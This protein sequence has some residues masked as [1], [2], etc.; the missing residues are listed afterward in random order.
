MVD[1]TLHREIHELANSVRRL[2]SR[3]RA[4]TDRLH[5]EDG[6]SA[7]RR[8]VLI[9][10]Y[11][12]GELTVPALAAVRSISR[13]II[14]TQV[15]DLRGLGYVVMKP[16]PEHKRSFLIVLTDS[17]RAFVET[18]IRREEAYMDQLGWQPEPHDLATCI[19]VLNEID[20]RLDD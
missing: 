6:L 14:Q 16:N 5:A 11:H 15:N 9:D 12:K 4:T 10:L 19:K 3:L 18:V 13:Q 20:A 1:Q 17:G 7:Q 2:H 8:T